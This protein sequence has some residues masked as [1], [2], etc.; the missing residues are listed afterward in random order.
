MASP[1]ML[2]EARMSKLEREVI[3]IREVWTVLY[4]PPPCVW[5]MYLA[6]SYLVFLPIQE[7]RKGDAK[8]RE[9]I[10][11][12]KKELLQKDSEVPQRAH[13]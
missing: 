10:E 11:E 9:E 12:L 4:T 2:L 7:S 13:Q 8:L 3:E 1:N 5:C 6:S